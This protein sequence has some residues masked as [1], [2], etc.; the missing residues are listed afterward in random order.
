MMDLLV[1]EAPR[2]S[3]VREPFLERHFVAGAAA[4]LAAMAIAMFAGVFLDSDIVDESYHLGNGYRFL[5]TGRLPAVTEHPPLAQAISALPLLLL[6]LRQTP[7]GSSSAGTGLRWGDG[8][9]FLYG[10]RVSAETILAFGRSAKVLLT[11]LFGG[12]IAWWTRRHFGAAP[13]LAA[14]LLFA[15][16]PT[17]IAHGHLA[18]TDV[19]AAFGFFGGCIA[20]NAFLARGDWRSA[21]WCG[22][23]TGLALAVKYSAL[24]LPPLYAY[25]YLIHGLQQRAALDRPRW[26]CS[27]GHLLRSMAVL[28]VGLFAALYASYGFETRPLLP[29]ELS[30]KP[31]S[32][33]LEANHYTAALGDVLQRHPGVKRAV[34]RAALD[35]P[36]PVPSFLRGMLS[37]SKH[38]ETGHTAYLLQQ[39]P[40]IGGWWYYFPVV[41]GVKTPTG[42]LALVLL[43]WAATFLIVLRAGPRNAIFKVLRARPEWYALTLPPLIY[44]LLSTTAHINVGIRHILP[45][46]P[47]IFIW[48]AA[49]L[50]T[51]RRPRLPAFFRWAALISLALVAVESA[52]AFPRYIAFFN[53]ASGGRNQGWKYVV[54][55]NLDWG[56]DMKRLQRYLE[57]R[58]VAGNVCLAT[59]SAAPPAHFGITAHSIPASAQEARDQGCLVVVSLSVLY[60][61]PPLDGSYNWLKRR[62]PTGRVADS[63]RIYDLRGAPD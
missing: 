11:L 24:L 58:G 3:P 53:W 40:R 9:D 18:T 44:F 16:D 50:F 15:F 39:T 61:W 42:L 48:T 56:Q 10:N 60:E 54:D 7:A 14:L 13:A 2:K 37:V 55:S 29:P 27:L 12:V 26:R 46:Y 4:L 43:A 1:A 22:I 35:T 62:Q 34:D 5:K 25:W 38:N 36:I 23:V 8:S 19:A 51:N 17:F 59:F 6:D 63:F 49:M 47:F 52:A 21:W 45:I 28:L 33:V 20:W 32:A 57:R 41:F 31:L 30:E